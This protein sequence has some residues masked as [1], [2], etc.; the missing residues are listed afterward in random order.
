MKAG[1]ECILITGGSGFIG[2]CLTDKV[3]SFN[4]HVILLDKQSSSLRENTPQSLKNKNVQFVL[5][6]CT[7]PSDFKEALK[8]VI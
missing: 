1:N 7:N 5:G 2:S 3:V 4:N 8:D 6:D